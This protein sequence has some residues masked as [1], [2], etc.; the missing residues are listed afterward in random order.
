MFST[1]IIYIFA[2]HFHFSMENEYYF[3]H[4]SFDED[5]I[6]FQLACFHCSFLM[7][8]YDEVKFIGRSKFI[9]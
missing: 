4:S 9:P 2:T 7:K 5:F 6:H 1:L 8:N 3:N